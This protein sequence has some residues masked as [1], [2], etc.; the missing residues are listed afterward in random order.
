MPIVLQFIIRT[1]IALG[2]ILYLFFQAGPPG[3]EKQKRKW[4]K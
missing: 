3:S 2:A 4:L 1:A